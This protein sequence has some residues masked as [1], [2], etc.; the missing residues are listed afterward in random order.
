MNLF[1]ISQ[2]LSACIQQ[3]ETELF[4]S[5]NLVAVVLGASVSVRYLWII[6]SHLG[7]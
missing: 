2:Q 7:D 4:H 5:T 1:I 3:A 6:P